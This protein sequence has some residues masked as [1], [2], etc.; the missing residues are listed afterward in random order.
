MIVTRQN[1]AIEIRKVRAG[2]V[3]EFQND[4]YIKV[5]TDPDYDGVKAVNLITGELNTYTLHIAGIV[6]SDAA[7][8]L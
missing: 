8:S 5:A 3:F 7:L 4:F 1:S 6:Y 2:T